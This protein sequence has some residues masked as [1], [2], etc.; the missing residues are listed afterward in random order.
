MKSKLQKENNSRMAF[1]KYLEAAEAKGNESLAETCRKK[2][3]NIPEEKFF[4]RS[5][6]KNEKNKGGQA[7]LVVLALLTI[8]GYGI[9]TVLFYNWHIEK[10]ISLLITVIILIVIPFLLGIGMQF[11]LKLDEEKYVGNYVVFNKVLFNISLFISFVSLIFIIFLKTK[12]IP[13]II[14]I[15]SL[16]SS[17]ILFVGQARN[18]CRN[19]NF[20][21]TTLLTKEEKSEYVDKEYVKGGYEY[22]KYDVKDSNGKQLGTI[23]TKGEYKEGHSYVKGISYKIVFHYKCSCCGYEHKK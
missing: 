8:V 9:G 2:L 3:K 15:I 10:H 12:N 13:T 22:T 18:R 16:G 19:C 4:N 20:Y 11:A 1:K 21:G 17:I 7:L 6:F 5:E 14:F 23:E